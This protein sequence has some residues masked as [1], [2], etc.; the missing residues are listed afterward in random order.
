MK[1]LLTLAV[2]SLL[3]TT[4]FADPIH[5]AVWNGDLE[6]VQAELDNG[7]DVDEKDDLW[8]RTP[9]HIAAEEGHKEVV[10]LLIDNGADVNAKSD[11]FERTPLHDA[12]WE[13]HKEVIEL[14]IAKGADVNAKDHRARTPM[15]IAA[16]KG[17]KE[18]V[19][20]LIA[21]GAK[22]NTKDYFDKTPLDRAEEVN[23]A[24]SAEL[25]AAKKEIA[26]LL[27]KHQLNQLM[28]RLVQHGRFAFSFDAK[29]GKVYEVQD[30]FDLLNWEPIRTYT[31]A[32]DT[33]RFDE[34]RDHDPPQWFYRVKM[35]E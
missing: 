20:L 6:G 8:G 15:H 11:W 29:E 13:V 17:H 25:K 30:S 19:E 3:A 23:E 7:V 33:V 9:L 12:I 14:L 4:A 24:D 5:S 27:R 34:D 21:K 10:E 28:P 22:V 32:G 16:Q 2:T 31:G 26:D 35:V 1:H 18:T